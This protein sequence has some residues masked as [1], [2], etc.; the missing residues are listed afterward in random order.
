MYDRLREGS[1]P[2][3]NAVSLL[4]MVVSGGLALTSVFVQRDPG[5]R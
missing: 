1:T 4:L 5:G 3:L 2:V